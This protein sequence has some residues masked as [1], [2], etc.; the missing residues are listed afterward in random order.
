MK[1][2]LVTL[3]AEVSNIN[4]PMTT[5]LATEFYAKTKTPVIQHL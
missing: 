3:Q 1:L 2:C 5:Q 4:Q